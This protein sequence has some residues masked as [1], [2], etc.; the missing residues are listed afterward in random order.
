VRPLLREAAPLLRD[1]GPAV[2]DLDT[3]T[4]PLTGATL[5]LT[6]FFNLL[7]HN[8]PGDDEGFLFWTAWAF[9]NL[10]SL[11]ST[12]DAHGAIARATR[13]VDCAG[14]QQEPAIQASLGVLGLCPE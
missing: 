1:A 11:A 9:H 3:A 10:N 14:V 8:P 6:Y 5:A 7:G 12:G 4:D 2:R 13:I